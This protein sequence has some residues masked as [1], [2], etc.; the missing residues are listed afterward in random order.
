METVAQDWQ[1]IWVGVKI[2]GV[3]G[4]GVVL[5]PHSHWVHFEKSSFTRSDGD[6]V[7]SSALSESNSASGSV[8]VVSPVKVVRMYL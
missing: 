5:G 7:G 8:S 6:L 1:G 2:K 4:T 3:V